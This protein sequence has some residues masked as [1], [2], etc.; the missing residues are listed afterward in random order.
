MKKYTSGLLTLLTLLS[1]GGCAAVRFEQGESTPASSSVAKQAEQ[2]VQVIV[3]TADGKSETALTFEEGD[4]VMDI[5]KANYDVQEEAGMVTAIDGLEQD[6]AKNTYWMYKV[7][8]VMADK[9][10]NDLH[11]KAGDVIEFYQE[12]FN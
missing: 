4:S 10:A 8:G 11:P 7:N 9:G 5:L 1:L 2:T 6:V 12:T 3:Q